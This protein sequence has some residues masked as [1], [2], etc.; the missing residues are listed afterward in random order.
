MSNRNFVANRAA[1]LTGKPVIYFAA[2]LA[3][4]SFAFVPIT[5]RAQSAADI[6]KKMS[7]VYANAKSYQGTIVQTNIGKSQD[8]KAARQTVK[9]NI[10]YKAPNKYN[11]VNNRTVTVGPT[12]QTDSQGMVSDGKSVYMYAPSKKLY[13]RAPVQN[14]SILARFFAQLKAS[15]GFTLLPATTVNG[16]AAYVLKPNAPTQGSPAEIANAKNV[17]IAVMIDK[18]NYHLLKMTLVSPSGSMSQMVSNQVVNGNIPDSAF[19]WTPPAGY[20]EFVP[21]PAPNGAPGGPGVPGRAP[22]R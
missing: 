18:Q 2:T 8:G 21:P 9:V 16:R 6:Y 4:A 15:N 7:D 12:T 19:A 3:A 10:N 5:A 14:Q 17:N 20:K 11:I 1:Q 22:G 13:Q